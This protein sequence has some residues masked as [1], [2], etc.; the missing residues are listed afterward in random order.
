VPAVIP[1]L[2]AEEMR[3]ADRRTI[4]DAGLP[5]A[6][7]MENA[8]SAVARALEQRFPDARRLIVL[9]G[10]GNNGGDGFVIARRLRERAE[11]VLLGRRGEVRGDA[12]LHLLACERSGGRVLEAPDEAG[13]GVALERL[14]R[15]DVVVDAL[16]GTGL[17][18]APTGPLAVAIDELGRLA[19]AGTP[20]VAVDIPSGVPSD[21]GSLAWPT[22]RAALTVTF[23]APKRG[24]V[25]PP[26][27][28]R[29]GEL[30]VADI[31]IT[32]ETL[33]AS[34]PSVFLLERSD[35]GAA[36]PPRPP[37]AHKGSFGHLLIV[38]GSVGKTGAAVLAALGALRAGVGLVT[39][40]TAA[41]ALPMVAA[42]RPEIMTEPLP[43]TEAGGP[44]AEGLD[45]LLGLARARDAVVIGPGLGLDPSTSALARDFVARCPVPTLVD[46]DGL[47]ALAGAGGDFPAL[48]RDAPTVL[49]PHPGEAGRLLGR[50]AGAIQSD[51]L[52]AARELAR[53]AGAL[54]VLKGQRTVVAETGGRAAVC[55]TGNPGLAKGGTGDVLA[56]IAGALLARHAPWL[57]ATA[58]VYVHGLAGDIAARRLGR[59]SLAAG[60]V[61]E[62]L[63]EAVGLV[64]AGGG[65]A[66]AT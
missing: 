65:G 37:G 4:E 15:A 8:G 47:N 34:A 23:A 58:A 54:A 32:R 59:E 52:G 46:A 14:R 42:G 51:R 12:L 9:C 63:P 5:G 40:A 24:H 35:A 26:A 36:F 17:R 21:D 48:A 1:V 6:V 57:A 29:V 31:G 20:I 66:S 18:A 50:T 11:A 49:T 16:L 38:G 19:E 60:D 55:P 45:R 22:V 44:A 28:D 33:L 43:A 3:R 30:V 56:G 7:L 2:T 41:P 62:A 39:V 25:L 13:W 53:R 10:K 61:L 64:Q 27:C